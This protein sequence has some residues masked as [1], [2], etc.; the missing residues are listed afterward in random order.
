[1]AIRLG[2]SFEVGA[3]HDGSGQPAGA[4]AKI[5]VTGPGGFVAKPANLTAVTPPAVGTYNV[6]VTC[7]ALTET[8]TV[9]VKPPK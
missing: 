8:A 3:F 2:K 6:R 9:T 5:K 1:M 4:A 7:G